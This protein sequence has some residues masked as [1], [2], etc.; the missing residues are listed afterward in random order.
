MTRVI[1]QNCQQ[2]HN[3]EV[4]GTCFFLPVFTTCNTHFLPHVIQKHWGLQETANPLHVSLYQWEKKIIFIYLF[5]MQ[6]LETLNVCLCRCSPSKDQFVLFIMGELL[7]NPP[8]YGMRPSRWVRVPWYCRISSGLRCV[9]STRRT[10]WASRQ[11]RELVFHTTEYRNTDSEH[12]THHITVTQT[13][14]TWWPN[15]AYQHMKTTFLILTE[16]QEG[17]L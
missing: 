16:L 7:W 4:L 9:S 15:A 10:A 13:R 12:E 5:S 3:Q 14:W 2:I 1:L 17:L 11:L 6:F 8:V